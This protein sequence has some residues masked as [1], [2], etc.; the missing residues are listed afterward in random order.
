MGGLL[1]EHMPKHA[2]PAEWDLKGLAAA[3][4]RDFNTRI[5]PEAWLGEEP[6]LEEQ[7]LRERVLRAVDEAYVAKAARV[8]AGNLRLAEKEVMLQK[9]DQHWREHLAGMEYLKQGIHL[10]GYAQ[11]DYRYEFKREAFE[12]FA[13][14]LD[15]VKYETSSFM[16]RI[17]IRTPEELQREEEERYRRLMR[18]LQ[19]Q[20][21]E[22]GSLLAGDGATTEAQAQAAIAAAAAA[23]QRAGVRLAPPPAPLPAPLPEAAAPFV[24]GERK[25]GRNEPCP[26]GSGKKYKHCHG[27]L[28]SV[29]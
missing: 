20:H 25:V 16:A 22:V 10:R 21:A 13:A 9:L 7:A 5:D 27:A 17:E 6:E 2:A 19:A 4:L 28:S 26:C 29:E 3:L 23:P 8:G 11:K 14:M 12:L 24:R 1:D 18:A 15:R